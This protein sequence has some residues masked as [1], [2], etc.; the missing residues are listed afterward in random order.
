MLATWQGAFSALINGGQTVALILG[1]RILEESGGAQLYAG[2]AVAAALVGSIA[3]VLAAV[4]CVRSRWGGADAAQESRLDNSR[5]S[6][7]GAAAEVV[8]GDFD[9]ALDVWEDETEAKGDGGAPATLLQPGQ[10][11]SSGERF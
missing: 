1:G 5:R 6:G 10:L 9:D 4:S 3:L 11:R 7:T 2:A 8:L